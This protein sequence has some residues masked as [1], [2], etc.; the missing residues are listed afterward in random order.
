MVKGTATD[1]SDID[2]VFVTDQ[3][4]D[5]ML[6]NWKMLAPLTAAIYY[7]EHHPYPTRHFLKGDPFIDEVK[8]TDWKSR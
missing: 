5:N 2:V 8:K 4:S 1:D 3:F 6:E 7:R